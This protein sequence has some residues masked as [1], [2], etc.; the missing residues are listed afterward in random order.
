MPYGFLAD[1]VVAAHFAYVGFVLLG[2]AAVLLGAACRWGWI[3]NPWFRWTHLGMIVIVAVEAIFELTCP[4]TTWERQLRI[5]AGQTVGEGSFIGR[6]LHDIIFYDGPAW[7]FT[8]AYIG[9]A[10]LVLG[11]AWFV[12]P[13]PM[14]TRNRPA[15][16]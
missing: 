13:R 11:T 7:V 14:R 3:R 2:Q 1:V 5:L 6:L 12:P 16:E 8:A 4:L 10:L 9:F 15:G